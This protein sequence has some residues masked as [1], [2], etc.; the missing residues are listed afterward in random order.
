MAKQAQ[1]KHTTG[2]NRE[3]RTRRW[4]RAAFVAMAVI[5]IL[6]WVISLVHF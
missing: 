4:Q 6:S 1:N 5:L 3:Q 2:L